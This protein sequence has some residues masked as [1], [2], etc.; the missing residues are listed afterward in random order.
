[1]NSNTAGSAKAEI[2]R[3]KHCRILGVDFFTGTAAEG[4]DL[5]AKGGLLVVPAAPALKDCQSTLATA[6][7]FSMPTLPS[8]T[9][10]S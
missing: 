8:P 3:S 10:L 1:M 5:I 4:V 9:V 2:S 7:R 6:T